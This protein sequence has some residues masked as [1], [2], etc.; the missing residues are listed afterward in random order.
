MALL[1]RDG[2]QE[3]TPLVELA[4]YRDVAAVHPNYFSRQRQTQSSARLC[5]DASVLRAEELFENHR[6]I[7]GGDADARVVDRDLQKTFFV[8]LT[9][10]NI[11]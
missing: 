4:F 2:N 3:R 5:L 8:E 10:G 1:Q 7:L 9:S 11:L 6:Q